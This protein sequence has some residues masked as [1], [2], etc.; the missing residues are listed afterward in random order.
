MVRELRAEIDNIGRAVSDLPSRQKT[1]AAASASMVRE[2][3]TEIDRL[4]RSVS[5]LPTRQEVDT[6][7]REMGQLAGRITADRPARLDPASLGAIDALVG[8]VDRMRRDAASPQMIADLAEELHA[9][10]ARLETL[11][12]ANS[13]AIDAVARRVEEVRAELTQFP[14]ASAVDTLASEIQSLIGRLDDQERVAAPTRQAV[15]GL[16]SRVEALDDRIANVALAVADREDAFERAAAPTRQAVVGLATRVEALDGR[17][18]NVAQAVS[19]RDDAFERAN[20]S[21]RA[22]LDNLPR[23]EA[24]SDLGRQIDALTESLKNRSAIGPALKAVEGLSGRVEALDGKIEAIA[25]VRAGEAEWLADTMRDEI[26]AAARPPALDGLERQIAA[27]TAKLSSQRDDRGDDEVRALSGKIDGLGDRLLSVAQATGARDAAFDRIEGEVRSISERLRAPRASEP[28]ERDAAF[29]RIEESVRVI[30]EQ[31]LN[32]RETARDGA[33]TVEAE[34][35]R[36]VDGLERNDGRLDDLNA[37]FAG[38]AA[39]VERS[40]ADLGARY[41]ETS[42]TQ[43]VRGDDE[44]EGEIVR[45]LAELR[46]SAAQSERRAADALDAVRATLE[47]LLDRMEQ[48]ETAPARSAPMFSAAVED[49]RYDPEPRREPEPRADAAEAARA[50]ARR[51]LAEIAAG[52]EPPAPRLPYADEP[53]FKAFSDLGDDPIEPGAGAPKVEASG[54]SAA[55]FIAAARR[56]S[57]QPQPDVEPEAPEAPAE[58]AA[59]SGLSGAISKLKAR[60]RPFLLGRRDADRVRR[61]LCRERHDGLPVRAGRRSRPAEP[62]CARSRADPR[63]LR[64]RR[65]ADRDRR[66]ARRGGTRRRVLRRAGRAR[67]SAARRG[68]GA[69]RRRVSRRAEARGERRAAHGRPEL[70]LRRRRRPAQGAHGRMEGRR[71]RHHGLD[72]PDRARRTARHHRRPTLRMRAAAGDPSAQL[73][74]ADRLLDGR[75]VEPD[76][77][78]AAV[79]LEKAAAQG[80]AP[81]QHRLGSLYEKGRGVARDV[82]TARR[83]YE[84]AAASGNVRAMHNLGVVY[85]EGGLGKPDYSAASVWFRMAAERGLVDSQYNLAVLDARGMSGKR[86]LVDAYKWFSLAAVQGDEDAAKKRDE[87]GKALGS[88]LAAAKVAVDAFR[89]RA[90]EPAANEVPSPP[91]GWDRVAERRTPRPRAERGSMKTVPTGFRGGGPVRG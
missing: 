36:L 74:V 48:M 29:D 59:R 86:N 67:S 18:A 65:R 58:P 23:A 70:R 77:A 16:A 17:I 8:E 62:P 63:A 57:A 79:W 47:R 69:L 46:A 42:A 34:I 5:D 76:A 52:D 81:A 24:V 37:A 21:I 13:T 85:A 53:R 44:L 51:A 49:T 28:V 75:N 60:K 12:P 68:S 32:P 82:T 7:S 50:A 15:V 43:G 72:R 84:Q 40:C 14:R 20:A 22:E 88:Q 61:A 91:G 25:K 30:A 56:A 89:P 10:S 55:S 90:V 78:S 54:P 83:W 9:I 41:Q 80:L 38:L 33:L 45:S 4:G 27:L 87:V 71:T 31:L 73:E 35:T 11:G 39:R 6:L 66:P 2:L 19:A 64:L 1:D 26:A 3:R